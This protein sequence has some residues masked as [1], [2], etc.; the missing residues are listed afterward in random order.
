MNQPRIKLAAI[1]IGSNAA[2]IQISSIL[3]DED[4]PILKKVE[5]IRFPLRLGKD[6]FST[7]EIGDKKKDKFIKLMQCF[8]L[9]IELHEV[10]HVLAFATSASREA[11]N[12]Q[13][14]IEE[15]KKL[16]DIDLQ[17]I[18]GEMEAEI[19]DL[20][21]SEFI[22]D[23]KFIHIDVGGGSTELNIHEDNQRIASKSFKIGSVR[24]KTADDPIWDD[25]RSWINEHISADC[26]NIAC[27]GT[28]GNINKIF[29]IAATETPHTLS[30]GDL[31]MTRD[32]LHKLTIDERIQ[33]LKLNEDRADVIVP[34]ADIY[35]GIMTACRAKR[36]LVPQVGLKDGMIIKLMKSVTEG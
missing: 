5:Y 12:G 23:Q 30:T 7:G 29:Q 18:D 21:L 9:M 19:T 20:A 35:L 11:S 28:G 10:K 4:S 6:V 13:A 33:R 26:G 8:K 3:G 16:T 22:D 34:A 31:K 25:I 14:I 36:I 17:I 1:D 24:V 2:R 27:L 15:I 32:Y